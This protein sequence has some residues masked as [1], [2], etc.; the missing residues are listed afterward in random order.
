MKEP[1]HYFVDKLS[2]DRVEV[3]HVLYAMQR[4]VSVELYS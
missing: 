2:I 4:H 1:H 3:D